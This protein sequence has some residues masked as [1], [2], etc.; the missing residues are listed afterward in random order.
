MALEFN[1]FIV[2]HYFKFGIQIIIY[3]NRPLAIYLYQFI[4]PKA[5][6]TGYISNMTNMIV[7]I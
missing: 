3:I 6:I 1:S 5:L 2:G 7:I 4:I